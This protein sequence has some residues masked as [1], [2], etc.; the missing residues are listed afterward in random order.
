MKNKTYFMVKAFIEEGH[1][2]TFSEIFEYMARTRVSRDLGISTYK[3]NEMIRSPEKIAPS[4]IKKLSK[5]IDLNNKLLV[6]IIK[7][8]IGHPLSERK[9]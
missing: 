4:D 3:V 8:Q 1:I 5:I 6:K 7:A 2:K 9:I